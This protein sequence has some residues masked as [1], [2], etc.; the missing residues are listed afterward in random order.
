M[1]DDQNS[2][3]NQA[4]A[5]QTRDLG[6]VWIVII[7]LIVIGLSF[8]A[9][10]L[11]INDN[12]TDSDMKIEE[13]TTATKT[14]DPAENPEYQK[15]VGTWETDCLIPN[16][17][18]NEVEKHQLVIDPDGSVIHQRQSGDSCA[19]I[20]VDNTTQRYMAEI[21]Q[22][23]KIN[24]I[25]ADKDS[26][27]VY[28]IYKIENDVLYFGHGFRDKYP[29]DMMNFGT[30]AETRYDSFNTFLAYKKQP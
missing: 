22:I 7:I 5:P 17:E 6:I 24:L 11:F 18:K 23:G 21:I 13:N 19:N 1:N 27:S 20:K 16:Q 8:Y 10:R 29:V 15:L 4:S 30:T 26:N 14:S 3:K 9:Y 12:L 28:D 25:G 2:D